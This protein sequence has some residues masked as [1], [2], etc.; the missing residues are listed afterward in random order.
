MKLFHSWNALLQCVKKRLMLLSWLPSRKT[1]KK[2]LG[3][4][5]STATWDTDLPTPTCLMVWITYLELKT[6][7]CV[8]FLFICFQIFWVLFSVFWKCFHCHTSTNLFFPA[9]PI[10]LKHNLLMTYI[11]KTKK[12][13]IFM[14]AEWFILLYF[15]TQIEIFE[16]MQLGNSSWSYPHLWVSDSCTFTNVHRCCVLSMLTSY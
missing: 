15:K 9:C 1:P 8:W 16:I 3:P 4:R 7:M 13:E 5:L 12:H 14:G 2:L 11:N 6:A 10:L